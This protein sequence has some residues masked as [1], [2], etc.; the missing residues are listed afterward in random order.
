VR[1]RTADAHSINVAADGEKRLRDFEDGVV[2]K[3]GGLAQ[4]V[5]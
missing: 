1:V 4:V 5:C 2:K 3:T